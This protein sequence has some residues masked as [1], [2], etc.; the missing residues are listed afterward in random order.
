[1]TDVDNIVLEHLRH[2]RGAVDG[3][4]EDMQEVKGRLG[5][6][7]S[8]YANM[9]NRMDRLDGRVFKIEQRLGLIE[10]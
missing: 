9:S 8:Q 7:E 1:M 2:I 3:L 10:A 4:R 5:I 6:L